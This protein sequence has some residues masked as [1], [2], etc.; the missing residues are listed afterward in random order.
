MVDAEAV[1]MPVTTPA[2]ETVA[3]PGEALLQVPPVTASESVTLV[4]EQKTLV[5]LMVPA[6]GSGLTVIRCVAFTVP[7][8]VDAA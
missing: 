2:E 7:H 4:P 1:E 5:P 3:T 6:N 8:A